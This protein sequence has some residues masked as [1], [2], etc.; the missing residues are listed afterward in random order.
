MELPAFQ[1]RG[2][3]QGEWPISRRKALIDAACKRAR[4][5][6][7]CDW[8]DDVA[9]ALDDLLDHLEDKLKRSAS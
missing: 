1:V 7:A 9:Y 2:D 8:H 4:E 5:L 6:K 3:E